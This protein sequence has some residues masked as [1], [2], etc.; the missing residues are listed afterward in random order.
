MPTARGTRQQRRSDIQLIAVSAVLVIVAGALIALGLMTA[1]RGGNSPTCA[2][3][4]LGA[5]DSIRQQVDDGGP[6]FTTGG[7]SCGFWVALD[8]GD[9]VAYKLHVPGRDCT[10][11][12]R[13]DRFSC[14]GQPIASADLAQY[15]TSIQTISGIDTLI[16]DLRSPSQLTTPST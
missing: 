2:R 14:G 3:L 16:V 8:G 12:Y 11:R 4:R 5:A 7:G 9:I 1:L 15:P 10:V 13:N 6:F